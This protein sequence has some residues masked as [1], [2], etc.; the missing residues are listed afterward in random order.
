MA[1]RSTGSRNTSCTL[2]E[3]GELLR[4]LRAL[5]S[6]DFS[7]RMPAGLDGVDGAIAR[8]FNDFAAVSEALAA[9]ESGPSSWGETGDL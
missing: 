2:L 3:R 8:A 9:E 7:T 1:L 4:A 5:K 6:G